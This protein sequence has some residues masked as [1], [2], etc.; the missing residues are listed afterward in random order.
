MSPKQIQQGIIGLIRD[1]GLQLLQ[2]DEKSQQLLIRL[3]LVSK[4]DKQYQWPDVTEPTLLSTLEQW[5]LPYL[6]NINS[7][8]QLIKL[9]YYQILLNLLDWPQQ[10]ALQQLL[11]ETWKMATGTNAKI[12]YDSKKSHIKRA[13]SRSIWYAYEPNYC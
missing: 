1:K 12:T 11:P 9:D 6:V 13:N 8:K 2:L 3:Q 10:Q 5:L 7:L 4:F